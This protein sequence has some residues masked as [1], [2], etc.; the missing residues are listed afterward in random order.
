MDVSVTLKNTI[1]A[2]MV[3]DYL[4]AS[5]PAGWL[6]LDGSVIS[7]S[8]YASL[9]A[10][11]GTTYNTGSEGVGN[12]RLPDNRGRCNMG[13]GTGSGLTAR[14]LG[15]KVGFENHTLTESELPSH[16]HT[17]N[18]HSHSLAVTRGGFDYNMNS[19]AYAANNSSTVTGSTTATNNPAGSGHAH[20]NMQPYLVVNK[21]IKF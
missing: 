20:N 16:N 2:G 9:F 14:T 10:I 5:A 11:F 8:T 1:K 19:G 21:I 17:Q 13:F 12:F 15:A 7:Q 6:L 18:P 3:I 4:G